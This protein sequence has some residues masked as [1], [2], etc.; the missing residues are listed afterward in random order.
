M[1]TYTPVK[2]V[3]ISWKHK[4]TEPWMNKLI[5]KASNKCKHLYKKSLSQDATEADKHKYKEYRNTYNKLK[6]TVQNEYYATKCREYG[7][8]TKQLWKMINDTICKRKHSGSI[9]SYI[10]INGV[11]TY[12]ANKIANEFGQYYA[13]MGAD[14]ARKIPES[15]KK[16]QE[17]VHFIPRTL[18]S[19]AVG[20]VEYTDIEEIFSALPAKMSSGHDGISNQ[21]LKQLNSSIS[22]PL[23]IIFNQSLSNGVFPEKVKLAEIV[24]LFKGKEEDMVVNYRLVSLLMTISKVL[25]KIMYNRMYGFLSRNNIFFDSQYSFRSKRSCEHAIMEMVG[26]VLQAKN[27]GKHSM[28]VFLDLSKAFDPLDHP[29]LIAKLE[30]YGIRGNMLDWFKS[31][32]SGRSLVAKISNNTNVTMYSEKYDITF[33]TAQGSCLVPL[34][35]IIFCNDIY[36][37]PIINIV[38]R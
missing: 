21:F 23:S 19:L 37:L 27:E 8:N 24:P 9:I 29:V 12:D 13:T 38:C 5:E 3:C 11:K 1:D 14:L 28:G 18:N 25:G 34:L 10:T 17:Y 26:H 16:V 30:R 15:K 7:K 32:L 4:F 35:F 6:Q 22:Y 20:R 36:M 31:Y 2:N 33:G